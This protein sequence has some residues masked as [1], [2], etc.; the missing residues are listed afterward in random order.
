MGAVVTGIEFYFLELDNILNYEYS[1]KVI[2]LITSA[3][4]CLL[5]FSIIVPFYI[6]KCTAGMFNVCQASQVVWSFLINLIFLHE[7]VILI[8]ILA[9]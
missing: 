7:K 6:Q 8:S 3:V 1:T 2:L 5:V 4:L 9:T